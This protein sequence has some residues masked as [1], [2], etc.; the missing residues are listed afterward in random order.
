VSLG[1]QSR[2]LLMA[3]SYSLSLLFMSAIVEERDERNGQTG[4]HHRQ[5]RFAKHSVTRRRRCARFAVTA[6]FTAPFAGDIAHREHG[7]A[8]VSP[9]RTCDV[10]SDEVSGSSR[11]NVPAFGVHCIVLRR[12]V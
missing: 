6:E 12:Q 1:T 3:R 8:S 2:Q 7:S 11:R 10:Q 5:D 9:L 4:R